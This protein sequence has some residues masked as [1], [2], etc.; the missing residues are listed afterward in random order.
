ML[1]FTILVPVVGC[2][3]VNLSLQMVCG[4]PAYMAPEVLANIGTYSPLCDVWSIGVILFILLS[5]TLPFRTQ[6]DETQLDAIERVKL[7]FK[8]PVTLALFAITRLQF[9]S[10]S[11]CFR[12]AEPTLSMVAA[13]S[14]N[15]RSLAVTRTTTHI[16]IR[17]SVHLSLQLV[18]SKTQTI[19]IL[20]VLCERLCK[21]K[22]A[23]LEGSRQS[24][25]NVAFVSCLHFEAYFG[26][27]SFPP[28]QFR[29]GKQCNPLSVANIQVSLS[30]S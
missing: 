2:S 7:T 15:C 24:C 4:T 30:S 6:G 22:Q 20:P 19:G 8:E 5:G 23:C 10:A 14:S 9:R 28:C 25:Q 3:V 26:G 29:P 18:P 17:M 16:R 11:F 13:S 12:P 21:S 1:T 27:R